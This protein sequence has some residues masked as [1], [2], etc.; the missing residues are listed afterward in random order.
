MVAAFSQR[1]DLWLGD[2]MIKLL[3]LDCLDCLDSVGTSI[4]DEDM[5]ANEEHEV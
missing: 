1:G 4:P 3:R 5:G 2:Q